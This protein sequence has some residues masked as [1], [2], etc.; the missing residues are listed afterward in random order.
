M[1]KNEFGVVLPCALGR[2]INIAMLKGNPEQLFS[3]LTSYMEQ[4]EFSLQKAASIL[5]E[6]VKTS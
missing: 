4:N 6:P 2:D 3:L 5:L 1:E